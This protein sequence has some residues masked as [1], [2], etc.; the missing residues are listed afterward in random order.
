[1]GNRVGD[2]LVPQVFVIR[3]PLQTLGHATSHW[4]S[5][6]D[7]EGGI[8]DYPMLHVA[9][10]GKVFMAGP[11]IKTRY[12]DTAGKG[13][14]TVGADRVEFA[15]PL[16]KKVGGGVPRTKYRQQRAYGSSVMYEPGKV[17]ILGGGAPPAST[18]EIIDLTKNKPQWQ[19]TDSMHFGRI[20]QNA[21]L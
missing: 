2:N 20:M 16:A 4:R 10:N 11:S 5:L 7:A 6:T 9:P 13:K 21:T 19:K 14:W 18:A 17:L 12:L 1:N 15:D 3:D 8:E